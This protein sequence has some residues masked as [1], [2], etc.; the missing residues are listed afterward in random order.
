LQL[1]QKLLE[2]FPLQLRKHIKDLISFCN[3]MVEIHVKKQVTFKAIEILYFIKEITDNVE[4][5]NEVNK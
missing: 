1:I 3:E 4:I 2:R 5:K